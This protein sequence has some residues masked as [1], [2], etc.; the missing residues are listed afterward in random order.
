MI[1]AKVASMVA[2]LVHVFLQLQRQLLQG[3]PTGNSLSTLGKRK[4]RGAD[5]VQDNLGSDFEVLLCQLAMVDCV[6]SVQTAT[7]PQLGM[8]YVKPR[9]KTEFD[10]FILN[11]YPEAEFWQ[12]FRVS[13]EFFSW[14]SDALHDS[15]FLPNTHFRESISVDKQI[16]IYLYY[17]AH[18]N[19]TFAALAKKFAVGPST[20]NQKVLKV[21][22]ALIALFPNAIEFPQDEA[23]LQRIEQE[24]RSKR[25]LPNCYGAVDCTHLYLN[26][27]DARDS[28]SYRDR[29]SQY[30]AI[31]QAVTDQTGRFLDV[32]VGYA[33]SCND[34]RVMAES[35]FFHS[36]Y[37]RELLQ[38][39]VIKLRGVNI[40]PYI[41]GDSGYPLRPHLMTPYPGRG[42]VTELRKSYNFYHSST[43]IVVERTFGQLKGRW[44]MLNGTMDFKNV[45]RLSLF[46]YTACIL[47]NL[48]MDHGVVYDPRWDN[49]VDTSRVLRNVLRNLKF[50]LNN[51]LLQT[52]FR[53]TST[54]IATC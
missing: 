25:G 18:E 5:A 33:G 27:P 43:R 3:T 6:S 10:M 48:C 34:A 41:I 49:G 31:M 19:I 53:Y 50:K 14:L 40:A 29:T 4:Y 38:K 11:D 26:L 1:E 17:L 37:A 7:T 16:A 20:A 23:R 13:R 52:S 30:S 9:N 46:A 35:P 22:N 39:P 45:E 24:F 32:F 12:D 54:S 15:L 42:G 36:I 51:P 2:L 28:T 44:R 21:A 8:Y 47:H